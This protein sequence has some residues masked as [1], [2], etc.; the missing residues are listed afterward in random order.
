[1]DVLIWS[2]VPK[3]AGGGWEA[4]TPD[5]YRAGVNHITRR[6]DSY[7]AGVIAPGWSY[8][9]L[10]ETESK[11]KAWCRFI[12][13]RDRRNPLQRPADASEKV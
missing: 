6:N 13:A 3:E 12:V 10:F 4:N 9:G 1:M 2:R 8:S 7:F 11:A 5:G